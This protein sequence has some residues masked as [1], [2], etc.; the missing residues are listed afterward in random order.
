MMTDGDN[1]Q[2]DSEF[3]GVVQPILSGLVNHSCFPNVLKS[4]GLNKK[5]IV[6][7]MQPI[8]KGSQVQL[9]IEIFNFIVYHTI[10]DK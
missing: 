4:I 5:V 2:F 10:T 7:A 1:I 8:Q 9:S 6:F 3:T